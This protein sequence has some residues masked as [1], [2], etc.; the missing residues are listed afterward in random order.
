MLCTQEN[1]LLLSNF[2]QA[3]HAGSGFEDDG[4]IIDVPDSF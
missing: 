3:G 1:L 2:G 4:S